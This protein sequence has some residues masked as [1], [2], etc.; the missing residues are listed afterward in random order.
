[1]YVCECMGRGVYPPQ[2][3]WCSRP[4]QSHV[5]PPPFPPPHPRKKISDILYAILCKFMRVFSEFW[6]LAVRD[7][8][9][10]K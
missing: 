8:D 7:N 1:M 2:Q 5:Y 4:P 3:P 6:K 9:S 10:T